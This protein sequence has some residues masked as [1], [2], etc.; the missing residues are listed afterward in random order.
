MKYALI[1]ILHFYKY[2]TP[3]YYEGLG[4]C[5][6]R[7]LV[8]EEKIVSI[9]NMNKSSANLKWVPEIS[10][11]AKLNSLICLAQVILAS[12]PAMSSMNIVYLDQEVN[13]FDLGLT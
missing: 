4:I 8:M 9:R 10:I 7:L 13:M 3:I 12:L 11:K 1:E 5:L 6:N 2:F